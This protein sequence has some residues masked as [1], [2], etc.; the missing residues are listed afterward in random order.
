MKHVFGKFAVLASAALLLGAC[1]QTTGTTGDGR[2]KL[3]YW[4]F[5][6]AAICRIWKQSSMTIT[7]V[8]M[9]CTLI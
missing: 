5:F 1:A 8:K 3:D 9:K 7:I 4:V 6:Q 2:M